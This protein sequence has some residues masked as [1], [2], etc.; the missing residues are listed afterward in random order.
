MQALVA[1]LRS[2]PT[3]VVIR[4]AIVTAMFAACG[5]A[6]TPLLLPQGWT[7]LVVFAVPFALLCGGLCLRRTRAAFLAVPLIVGFWLLSYCS[8]VM[9]ALQVAQQR[10]AGIPAWAPFCVGG[11]VGGLGIVLCASICHPRLLSSW[12]YLLSGGA[13]GAA[14]GL[15]FVPSLATFYTDPFESTPPH[16]AAFAV[17]QAAMGALLYGI[18]SRSDPASDPGAHP[19][20]SGGS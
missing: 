15:A 16:A 6:S 19:G 20:S 8:T 4:Y 13:V 14:A 10:G 5:A 1:E 11:L 2:S 17:W 7:H 18:C 9:L 3:R 12:D